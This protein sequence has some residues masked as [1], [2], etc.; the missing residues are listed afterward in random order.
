MANR[1]RFIKSITGA[2]VATAVPKINTE[3]KHKVK[4]YET[5]SIESKNKEYMRIDSYGNIKLK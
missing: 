4:M 3:D 1:R 2:L 5:K